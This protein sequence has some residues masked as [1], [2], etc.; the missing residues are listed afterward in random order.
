[1]K[2]KHAEYSFIKVACKKGKL[3]E[4][5]FKIFTHIKYINMLNN[6]TKIYSACNSIEFNGAVPQC[7]TAGNNCVSHRLNDT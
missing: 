5:I 1:M 2:E 7:A 6:K 4:Y 3:A